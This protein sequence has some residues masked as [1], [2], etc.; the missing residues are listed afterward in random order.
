MFLIRRG[1]EGQ[2]VIVRWAAQQM[3]KTGTQ[4][5][6]ISGITRRIGREKKAKT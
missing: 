2:E 1:R 4:G 5:E 6:G 3:V